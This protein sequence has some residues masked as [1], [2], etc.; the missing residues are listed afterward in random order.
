M[1]PSHSLLHAI[2]AALPLLPAVAEAA[3]YDQVI[4]TAKGPVQG[5]AAFNTTPTG[6]LTNWEDIT[7]WKGIPFAADTAG[8]NRFRVP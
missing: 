6:G 3:L 4:N 2:A 1:S 5:Y 7:V 8:Q